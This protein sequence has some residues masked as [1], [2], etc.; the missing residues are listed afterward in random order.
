MEDTNMKKTY[1]IP[2]MNVVKFSHVAL[3]TPA[4]NQVNVNS[5]SATEW[6][7]RSDDS[8]DED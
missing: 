7:S 2:E 1:I 6:G 4:S 8:W 3:L 5:G